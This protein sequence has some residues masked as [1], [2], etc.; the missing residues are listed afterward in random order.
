VRVLDLHESLT[1]DLRPELEILMGAVGLVLLMVAANLMSLLLTRAVGRRRDM[2]VRVAL[3]A[4]GWRI[5]RQ[6]LA[7]NA[8]LCFAGGV[9]GIGVAW[10]AAP[11][12]MHLSPINIP[13]FASLGIGGSP[14]AFAA[15]LTFGCTLI[16]SVVP[17]LEARRTRPNEALHLNT[18]RIAAGRHLAQRLLIIGEVAM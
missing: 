8:L 14:I 17:A 9:A 13:Q 3:G 12:L 4:T 1:G 15:A 11:L 16:F 18:S 6:L 5:V 2:G 7:E 10:V